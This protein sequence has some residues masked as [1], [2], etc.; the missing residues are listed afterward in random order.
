M[1]QVQDCD[2]NQYALEQKLGKYVNAYFALHFEFQNYSKFL[3]KSTTNTTML[4]G[5]NL[6]QFL[7]SLFFQCTTKLCLANCCNLGF[8]QFMNSFD[9]MFL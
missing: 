8:R 9:V 2:G 4:A 3:A 6:M 7:Q 5:K 1:D